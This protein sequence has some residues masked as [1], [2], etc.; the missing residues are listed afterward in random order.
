[1]LPADNVTAVR[2]GRGYRIKG[3]RAEFVGAAEKDTL[4][5]RLKRAASRSN[6]SLALPVDATF[7]R[8]KLLVECFSFHIATRADQDIQAE[9]RR[10]IKRG[11]L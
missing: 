2:E 5:A 4:A 1:V 6:K 7:E 10:R 3:D 9:L 11:G 8:Y